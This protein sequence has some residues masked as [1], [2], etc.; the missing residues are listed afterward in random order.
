MKTKDAKQI[1]KN[2][3]KQKNVKQKI[4]KKNKKLQIMKKIKNKLQKNTKDLIRSFGG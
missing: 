3:N 1:R 4:I 2:K